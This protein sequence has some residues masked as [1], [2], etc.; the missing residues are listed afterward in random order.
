MPPSPDGH[1]GSK[2]R[3]A[4]DEAHGSGPKRLLM[5]RRLRE[6][7]ESVAIVWLNACVLLLALNAGIALVQRSAGPN[8][9]RPMRETIALAHPNLDAQSIDALVA[10]SERHLIYEPY[11]DM[12]DGPVRGRFVNVDPAGFRYSTDQGPWPP[13]PRSY[14]VFVFGGS[15][16]FG[17]ASATGMRSRRT[18]SPWWSR[19]TAARRASTTS[20]TRAT[21]RRRSAFSSRA[22][23][24][25]GT[26]PT[27]PSSW[28]A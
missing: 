22:S 24:W 12:T 9:L 18:F 26:F 27:L 16:T 1:P 20:A 11:T 23:W 10:E 4:I 19:R 2:G 15:T 5:W 28:T 25:R 8:V 7:R 6:W 13:D 14:N 17:Y 3:L 21:T